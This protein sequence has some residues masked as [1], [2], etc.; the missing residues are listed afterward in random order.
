LVPDCKKL[1][2]PWT[3]AQPHPAFHYFTPFLFHMLMPR[4]T[5]DFENDFENKV[6]LID[7]S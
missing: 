7:E 1:S 5:A 4:S 3:P 2:L 6:D